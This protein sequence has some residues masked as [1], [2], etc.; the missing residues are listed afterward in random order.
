MRK[1]IN[2]I[3]PIALATI[4]PGLSLYSTSALVSFEAIGFMLRWGAAS[5]F[6]YV[7]WYL[8]W[9]MWALKSG[10]YKWR[11]IILLVLYL[12]MFVIGT[13][14]FTFEE[15]NG[16][17]KIYIVRTTL[18][19]I[20]FLAIQFAL[21]KQQDISRLLLEKEQVQTENYKAQLRGLRAKVDP[22]FL[23]NS[24]N[25]LRSMVR[26]QHV[27][28]EQFII[29]L[30]DFYRQTLKHDENTTLPLSE[31]LAVLQSYLFV[32][33]NRNEEGVRVNINVE[34][35]LFHLHLPTLALQ[36]VVENC[37]K[38]NSMA[39]KMPLQIEISNTDDA[40]IVVS[41][42]IQPKIG[43]TAPSGYGLDLLNKR[44]ELMNIPQG[45]IIQEEPDQFIV[46]L[47][48]I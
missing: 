44:Y 16:L 15:V 6:L 39:S 20:L 11:F 25:T 32:M 9:Y 34:E 19:A 22:H 41:N 12:G 48:L 4:L 37:F 23:F 28:A 47:K 13:S 2:T 1:R 24:L 8:L 14:W 43:D 35:S 7:L 46:K 42:N 26:Q 17:Y 40:Y 45:L 36:I 3:L 33:K 38:H 27:N 5:V 10:Q 21:K 18:A 30:S 29:S 31:E